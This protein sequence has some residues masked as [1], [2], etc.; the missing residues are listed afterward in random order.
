MP[1][2]TLW[3]FRG[4][5][6]FEFPKPSPPSLS[7]NTTVN[8]FLLGNKPSTSYKPFGLFLKTGLVAVEAFY[9]CDQNTVLCSWGDTQAGDVWEREVPVNDA[10]RVLAGAAVVEVLP[11]VVEVTPGTDSSSSDVGSQ[12]VTQLW[13]FYEQKPFWSALLLTLLKNSSIKF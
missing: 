11:S 9:R 4:K 1:V 6:L 3:N 8:C 12:I 2:I 5:F 13:I 7:A 10:C